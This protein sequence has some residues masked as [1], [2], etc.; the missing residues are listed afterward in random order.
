MAKIID[1]VPGLYRIIEIEPFR[2]TEGV[3][4]D[5]IPLE[6]LSHIDS[7][8]R[9][10]HENAAVS[11][12]KVGNVERPWY[13]HPF[14]DDNLVVLYGKREVDIYTPEHG[15]IEHFTVT[16]NKVYKNGELISDNGAMLVWPKNV[17]HRI[18]SGEDGSAS[19]NFAVHYEGFNIKYNF[20]I[21]DVDTNS[22]EYK[23]IREGYKDQ[24]G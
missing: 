2:K 24:I 15:K 6:M 13:M 5:L 7:L 22:G 10:I 20:S 3:T 17:F 8:D 11:P 23:L 12:G 18:V 4:F 16:S 1:E 21:Y 19:L 9:V 14:Q